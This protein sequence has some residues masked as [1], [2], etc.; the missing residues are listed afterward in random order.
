MPDLIR[1]ETENYWPIPMPFPSSK[2]RLSLDPPPPA[3]S[4]GWG[5]NHPCCCMA[6][7]HMAIIFH[8]GRCRTCSRKH[9]VSNQP[10]NAHLHCGGLLSIL[11]GTP[12]RSQQVVQ[13]TVTFQLPH[14]RTC[15]YKPS[16]PS[17]SVFLV[18]T[19]QFK[20][21]ASDCPQLHR[22]QVPMAHLILDRRCWF[23]MVSS[24]NGFPI[25]INGAC[26][27]R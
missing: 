7:W 19:A 5:W 14:A 8:A 18:S 16:L 26:I 9:C 1:N 24:S 22:G 23:S 27:D 11:A 13:V 6:A 21:S 20:L 15:M 3:L 2:F 10:M 17:S 25:T 4:P 12:P